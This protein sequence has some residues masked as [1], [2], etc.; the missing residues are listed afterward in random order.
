MMCIGHYKEHV[1]SV[2]FVLFLLKTH[3]FYTHHTLCTNKHEWRSYTTSLF[4]LLQNTQNWTE[5]RTVRLSGGDSKTVRRRLTVSIGVTYGYRKLWTWCWN[6]G[7]P[8]G[9]VVL[10]QTTNARITGD[11]NLFVMEISLPSG[12]FKY[13]PMFFIVCLLWIDEAEANIWM[14]IINRA[15]SK[16]LLFIMNRWSES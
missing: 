6:T 13:G 10:D 4:T 2:F 8:N 15:S 11:H 7:Y 1:S 14:F 9:P 12:S 5:Q 16:L 3:S